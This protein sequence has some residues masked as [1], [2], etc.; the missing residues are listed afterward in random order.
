MLVKPTL[1]HD[2][3]K[4]R[5]VLDAMLM[6]SQAG[7]MGRMVWSNWQERSRSRVLLLTADQRVMKKRGVL[8]VAFEDA[9]V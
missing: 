9:K 1:S 7:I 4:S 8:C 5:S 3:Y 2:L 6:T